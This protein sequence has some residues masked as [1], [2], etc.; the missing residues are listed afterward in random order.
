L[1][2][3]AAAHVQARCTW[4]AQAARLEALYRTLL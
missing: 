2:A 4:A 1:G 3:A